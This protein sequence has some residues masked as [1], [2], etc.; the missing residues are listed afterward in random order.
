VPV[1]QDE[2]LGRAVRQTLNSAWN[3]AVMRS[4]SGAVALIPQREQPVA[5]ELGPITKFM[6]T[7]DDKR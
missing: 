6:Q 2:E 4:R 1:L 7:M 5:G 3:W